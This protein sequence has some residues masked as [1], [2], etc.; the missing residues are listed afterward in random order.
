M[1]DDQRAR[2]IEAIRRELVAEERDDYRGTEP[3][4]YVLRG[5]AVV[6]YVF[7][8]GASTSWRYGQSHSDAME[9]GVP[10]EQAVDAA[11]DLLAAQL[12]D[13]K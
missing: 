9:L 8:D 11:M 4:Y 6:G 10:P 5:E 1:S 2:T 12:A 3:A 7:W 13:A